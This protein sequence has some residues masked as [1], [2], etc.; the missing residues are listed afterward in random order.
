VDAGVPLLTYFAA[1][2]RSARA[3]F[4]YLEALNAYDTV[5]LAHR[6]TT[7]AASVRARLEAF[8]AGGGTVF[9][10]AA[11]VAELGGLAGVSAGACAALPAGTPVA[12]AD[13]T[14]PPQIV[15]PLPFSLCALPALPGGATVLA[16]I[17]GAPAAARVPLGNGSLLVLAAGGYGMA[18]Q[19]GSGGPGG[20]ARTVGGPSGRP[21]GAEY[22][23]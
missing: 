7:D 6:L 18:A 9:A 3:R 1:S 17:G 13:G 5:V 4:G 12:L 23:G 20:A 11:T 16:T 14:A 10:T 22:S 19:G 15:E 8:L 2:L 21:S